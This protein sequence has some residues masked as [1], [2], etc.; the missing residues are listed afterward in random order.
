MR[1]ISGDRPAASATSTIWPMASASGHADAVLAASIFHFGEYTVRQAKARAHAR[2]RHRGAAVSAT[3][4][5]PEG[6]SQAPASRGRTAVTSPWGGRR[7][8]GVFVSDL[9]AALPWLDAL[10]PGMPTG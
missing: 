6:A 10:K 9:N 5:R 4:G 2:T 3:L 8:E 7:V 1:S